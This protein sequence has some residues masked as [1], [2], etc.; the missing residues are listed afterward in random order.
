MIVI[1][2]HLAVRIYHFNFSDRIAISI[3]ISLAS[4]FKSLRVRLCKCQTLKRSR[5]AMQPSDFEN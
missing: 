1:A 3:V 5:T 2:E 4:R